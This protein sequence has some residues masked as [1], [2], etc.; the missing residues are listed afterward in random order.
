M[1]QKLLPIEA[2]LT[3]ICDCPA[4]NCKRIAQTIRNVYTIGYTPTN[5]ELDG[6]FRAIQ[7]KVKSPRRGTLLART[8]AG[9]IA[10]PDTSASVAK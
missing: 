5:G 6:K 1:K 4:N 8:R 9:Y 2:A 10:Q 3:F 7:V